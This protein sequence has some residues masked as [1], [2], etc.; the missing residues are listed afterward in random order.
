M[1]K[2]TLIS[3]ALTLISLATILL[4]LR[5]FIPG[6]KLNQDSAKADRVEGLYIFIHSQP[7]AEYTVLGTVKKTGLV[8]TGKPSEIFKIILR[9][10]QNDYPGTE[11]LIFD[12][13][14]LDKATCIKFK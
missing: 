7:V 14:N 11:G 2:A 8:W 9:R 4:S 10:A 3:V 13:I 6:D 1:K 12:D 5:P